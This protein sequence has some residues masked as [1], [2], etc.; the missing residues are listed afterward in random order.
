MEEL[1]SPEDGWTIEH[2]FGSAPV[3]TTVANH[4]SV[5]LLLNPV[6]FIKG[7]VTEWEWTPNTEAVDVVVE[8]VGF[9][10]IEVAAVDNLGK[11]VALI[12]QGLELVRLIGWGLVAAKVLDCSAGWNMFDGNGCV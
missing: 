12:P 11:V 4:G 10:S 6:Q 9:T 8:A 7:E 3:V 1:G 5:G 2:L